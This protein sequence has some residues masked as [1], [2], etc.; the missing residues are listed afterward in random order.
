MTT[1]LGWRKDRSGD[2]E[3]ALISRE[4]LVTNGLG[5]YASGTIAGVAT[6]RYHGLLIA[7]LP[8]PLGRSMMFNHLSEQVR[9]P[10]GTVHRFGSAE[11]GG[12]L[13]MGA[14]RH[15]IDFKLELGLPVWTYA[16]GGLVL[17]KRL[18]MSYLQNSVYIIYRLLDGQGPVRLS[19][20]P[21]VQFRP[22][23]APVSRDL[24]GPYPLTL[25]G[26]RFELQAPTETFPP[27]RMRVWGQDARFVFQHDR[28]NSVTYRLEAARG[29]EALGNLWSHGY[30]K[31]QL[32]P[33]TPA[34]LL[35]STESWETIV[36]LEPMQ[37]LRYERDRRERLL[38]LADLRPGDETAAELVLAAD[39]F[40]IA[41]AGRIDDA[42]R[43]RAQGEELRTVIA[44]YHWFTDWGR[45][46]MISLEGLALC[47]GRAQ[48]ARF[49]LNSFT[50][51]LRDGLIP[52][53]FPEGAQQGLYHTA[54]ATLWFFHAL[55]R[56]LAHTG[57]RVTLR[58]ILP[59][60][61]QIVAAHRQGTRF[62][63]R[64]DPADGLLTQGQESLALTWMDAKCDGWVVTPR[65]GKA[66]EINALWYNALRL[67]E[68]WM[69][70]ERGP[71]A[72]AEYQADAQ[73]VQTSFNLRFWYA[74]GKYL[75][76]VI[77]GEGGAADPAF[78]PNQIL[79][80]SLPNPVLAPERWR[81]V[82]DA[83]RERLLTPVGLRS[84][85][86]EHP[87]YKPTYHG[88]LR[89]RD[90]AYHQGTGWSWLIG[91]FIDAWL[92]VHP[93]DPALA[94]QLLRGLEQHLGEACVG[95]ISE[96]FDAESPFTPRGCIAQAWGVAEMLRTWLRIHRGDAPNAVRHP[97]PASPDSTPL[98]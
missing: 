83:V 43:A 68:R 67:M 49:I 8:N 45:D 23:D 59:R 42:T 18:L 40:L 74:E 34:T 54:D 55:D 48:E 65:R 26:D 1:R 21:A 14:A 90:A 29:Y 77:D 9:L 35:A 47:T 7:A 92:K 27:L 91:P 24:G 79:A 53:L 75:H 31:M 97:G 61:E 63:I 19:L 88:D 69:G 15:L 57:D 80:V 95:S 38:R 82:V 20:R 64:V 76:D 36:A 41:P 84:L 66:V 16:I 58:Q 17:E 96:V 10:D 94:G 51:Y 37:A 46:T 50:H 81:G 44:G 98:R 39:Q 56:Y 87:D 86:R 60:L 85:A 78:R 71:A 52:N 4:W 11:Q 73:R 2:S 5:G 6:R 28:Q 25:Q 62:G 12:A 13:E 22:H 32:T 30:F 72:A 93:E 3:D 33:E 89:T 70:E